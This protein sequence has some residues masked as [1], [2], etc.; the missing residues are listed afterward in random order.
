MFQACILHFGFTLNFI[1]VAYVV[2]NCKKNNKVLNA[3]FLYSNKVTD[4]LYEK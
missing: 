3:T 1:Q 4:F 2:N